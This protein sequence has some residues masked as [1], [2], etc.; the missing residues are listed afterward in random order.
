M[1]EVPRLRSPAL[2]TS[3]SRPLSSGHSE[4]LSYKQESMAVLSQT[5]GLTIEAEASTTYAPLSQP[6]VKE[7]LQFLLKQT[8]LKS[9]IRK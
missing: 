5:M 2:E 8:S 4:C 7:K 6:G 3:L 1:P 9:M